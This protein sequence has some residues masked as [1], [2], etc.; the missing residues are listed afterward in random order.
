[1]NTDTARAVDAALVRAHLA[2]IDAQNEAAT[3][4]HADPDDDAARE[5]FVR[6]GDLDAEVCD[7]GRGFILRHG[8]F[9]RR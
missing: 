8:P 6:L 5:L 7:L 3:A 2:I 1:M 9:A 4:S